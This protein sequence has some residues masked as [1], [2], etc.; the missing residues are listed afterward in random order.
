MGVWGHR[1]IVSGGHVAVM[2]RSRSVVHR[3]LI[4]NHRRSRSEGAVGRRLR[5]MKRRGEIIGHFSRLSRKIRRRNDSISIDIDRLTFSVKFDFTRRFRCVFDDAHVSFVRALR[6]PNSLTDQ[7]RVTTNVVHRRERS[8]GRGARRST[9]SGRTSRT[10]SGIVR[11]VGRR[12]R[13]DSWRHVRSIQR[14][15]ERN[16]GD[17]RCSAGQ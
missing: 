7:R 14:R 5:S 8:F 4:S 11:R 10:S 3:R 13:H 2:R 12:R 6:D 16:R 15:R 1:S 17:F 9:S